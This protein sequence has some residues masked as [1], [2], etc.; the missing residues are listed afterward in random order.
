[1]E[2]KISVSGKYNFLIYTFVSAV[3]LSI[4]LVSVDCCL[5]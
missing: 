5:K 1:M 3:L 4:I 2:E